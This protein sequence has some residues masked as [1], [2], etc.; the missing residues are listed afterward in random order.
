MEK[1]NELAAT[2][3]YAEPTSSQVHC[4]YYHF[5]PKAP[6]SQASLSYDKSKLSES[7]PLT[8]ESPPTSPPSSPPSIGTSG[9]N[10]SYYI[11]IF[12]R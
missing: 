11:M 8:S 12:C 1:M 9:I 5:V 10:N 6:P 3:P 2:T 7:F 4:P